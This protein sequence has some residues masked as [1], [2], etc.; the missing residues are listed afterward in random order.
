MFQRVDL[1]FFETFEDLL[2]LMYGGCPILNDD[3]KILLN[4]AF[5]KKM[6]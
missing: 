6:F 2:F 4:S 5:K 3:L 1:G